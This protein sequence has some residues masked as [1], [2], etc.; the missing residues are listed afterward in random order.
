MENNN[1]HNCVLVYYLIARKTLFQIFKKVAMAE[2]SKTPSTVHTDLKQTVKIE[3]NHTG[4]AVLTNVS[5][6]M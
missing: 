5:A 3:I 1:N 6:L 4:Y 2:N